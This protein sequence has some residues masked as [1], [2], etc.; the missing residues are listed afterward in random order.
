[1]G[2][3]ESGGDEFGELGFEGGAVGAGEGNGLGVGEDF[4]SLEEAGELA[5][6]RGKLRAV[7]VEALLEAGD[8]LADAAEEEYE[9]CWP[10]G[11]EFAPGCLRAA[12]G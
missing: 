8:L 4:V 5:G 6:E 2:F 9:P 12:E 1:M 10:V 7:G 11:G 3:G